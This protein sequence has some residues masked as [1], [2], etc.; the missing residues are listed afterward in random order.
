MTL[1]PADGD[2]HGSYIDGNVMDLIHL[3]FATVASKSGLYSLILPTNFL[4]SLSWDTTLEGL[5]PESLEMYH[6]INMFSN[7]RQHWCFA[8][9]DKRCPKIFFLDPL[10]K[11]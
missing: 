4:S 9:I 10:G 2:N 1:V 8:G 5:L 3:I 6:C 7:Q 11:K